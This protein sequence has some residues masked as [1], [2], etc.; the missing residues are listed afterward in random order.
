[1]DGQHRAKNRQQTP[2][3]TLGM[4]GLGGL[5]GIDGGGRQQGA[6]FGVAGRRRRTTTTF[7]WFVLGVVLAVVVFENTTSSH[8]GE[9]GKYRHK[10]ITAAADQG[11]RFRD[12]GDSLLAQ[13]VVH[14]VGQRGR[15]VVVGGGGGGPGR[16]RRG[17][18]GRRRGQGRKRGTGHHSK[19]SF[20][21]ELKGGGEI[22]GHVCWHGQG[23]R[24]E[25]QRRST[26]SGGGSGGG[27][28]GELAFAFVE[29]LNDDA[30]CKIHSTW[31]VRSQ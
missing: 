31:H 15:M 16:R 6:T 30:S 19:Q 1:M 14:Q 23:E 11:G 29:C 12:G 10:Q 25:R 9:Q 20:V 5:S 8:V 2:T 26:G 28:C 7:V 13:G 27:G 24:V 21:D 18:R 22:V 4:G 17:R 3:Q